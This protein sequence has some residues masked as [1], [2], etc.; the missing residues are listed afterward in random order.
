MIVGGRRFPRISFRQI[1][2][3]NHLKII[4]PW[5][6]AVT[7]REGTVFYDMGTHAL[8]RL[9]HVNLIEQLFSVLYPTHWQHAQK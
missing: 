8:E 3:R 9:H 4:H 2:S 1:L 6:T 5:I 7:L